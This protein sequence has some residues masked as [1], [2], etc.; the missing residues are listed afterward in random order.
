ML[1]AVIEKDGT[2]RTVEPV[3]GHPLLIHAARIA[4][5][6]WRYRPFRLEGGLVEVATMIEL[7]F[8]LPSTPQSLGQPGK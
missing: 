3:R 6:K 5:K 8:E 7:S 4:V 2:V 1:R